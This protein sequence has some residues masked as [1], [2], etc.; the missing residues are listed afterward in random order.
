MTTLSFHIEPKPNAL[1]GITLYEQIDR[2]VLVK[3]INSKLLREKFNNNQAGVLYKNEKQQLQRY[4]ELM[5]NGRIPV[6]YSRNPNNPYGRSNPA[7]ALGLYPI[8]REVRHTLAS[9]NMVDL[10]I[11]NAHPEMLNQICEVEGVI[12][13]KLNDY[14]TNRQEH[15]DMITKSYGC[16][17]ESAKNIFIMYS[18]GGG[19]KRWVEKK[20]IDIL[21]CDPSVVR[22]IDEIDV[23]IEI[24]VLIKFRESMRIIHSQIEKKNPDL[25]R[26]VIKIKAERG[27]LAGT[28]AGSVCSFVLQEY[29]IRVLEQLFLYCS[30]NGL[31]ENGVCVLCADGLMIERRFYKENL[32]TKFAEIIRE[33]IGF[34]LVF[35]QKEMNKGYLAVLNS[36]LCFDLYT[37]T[38]STGFMA[39]H[40]SV[41]YSNKFLC[42]GGVV[43][44]YNDVF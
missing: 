16:D 31:I 32:L 12:H 35:T 34:N 26:T 20:N 27:E 25:C 42:V 6:T 1:D 39:E 43:Y 28:L 22:K 13:D 21:K 3:L 2:S 17:E 11:K 36:N 23:I 5:E 14:V 8:R 19:F 10:D 38:F 15:F 30:D 9:P 24:D 4:L 29:E 44:H 33:T 37:P 41:M 40:F 7:R 18:Y